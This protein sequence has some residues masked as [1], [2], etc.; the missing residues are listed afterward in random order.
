MPIQ[1][2]GTLLE[3]M[4]VTEA[5]SVMLE[6]LR[7]DQCL[8]FATAFAMPTLT[9]WRPHAQSVGMSTDA[10][11]AISCGAE[12]TDFLRTMSRCLAYRLDRGPNAALL[13]SVLS[14]LRNSRLRIW[15]NDITNGHYGNAISSLERIETLVSDIM[16]AYQPAI[17]VSTCDTP[18][19]RSLKNLSATLKEWT[20][21]GAVIGFLDPN[22]YTI[23]SIFGPFTRS[24]D[25]REWL[26]ILSVR[27]PFV[28]IHF[29]GNSDR[30]SFTVELEE[31]RR[32]LIESAIPRWREF[33]RQH[34]VVSVG[35]VDT[36]ILAKIQ[37]RVLAS[38]SAW[39]D[40]VPE[41]KT[42]KLRVFQD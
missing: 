1:N 26:R 4:V 10:L 39:C 15:A 18:Y 7:D 16:P 11:E 13:A 38:W 22:R 40:R 9:E 41:I 3:N 20:D 2:I 33:R 36:D 29:T 25:H 30:A 24:A 35:C 12:N 5:A 6:Q 37:E 21:V 27:G 23:N 14:T 28:A 32:D 34:Y 19:P 31:L 8:G 17:S 42:R